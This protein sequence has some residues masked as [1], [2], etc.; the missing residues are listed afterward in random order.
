MAL[1]FP[2]STALAPISL[3]GNAEGTFVS[4]FAGSISSSG[5]QRWT[6]TICGP[7][8]DIITFS[9]G[10]LIGAEA[11]SYISAASP[12]GDT[13]RVMGWSIKSKDGGF[14][15][16]NL[17]IGLESDSIWSYSTESSD[18]TGTATSYAAR[19]DATE[20]E[21]P[22]TKYSPFWVSPTDQAL[23]I[24]L[25]TEEQR[26]KVLACATAGAQIWVNGDESLRLTAFQVMC[27]ALLG[28]EP[29][30]ISEFFDSCP[31]GLCARVL[32][33]M[34]SERVPAILVTIT[35]KGPS[36]TFDT[37]V[38]SL[39]EEIEPTA[40]MSALK[41]PSITCDEGNVLKWT[42][43]AD[44][45]VTNSDADTATRTTTFL[46]VSETSSDS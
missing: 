21:I 27:E 20:R 13:L 25:S 39:G 34:L 4:S 26:M 24:S 36:S 46:G 9:Q 16:L 35:I 2:D 28:V 30:S 17:S 29:E 38:Y 40:L 10:L 3:M 31:S 23:P 12:T 37:S 15:E 19:V 41:V 22:L 43:S 33:G 42:V 45:V 11:S 1:E 7:Y 18:S 6:Y 44:S 32:S 14:A 5:S 8:D